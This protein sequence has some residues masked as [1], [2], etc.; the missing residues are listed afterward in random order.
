MNK[1]IT[2][3]IFIYVFVHQTYAQNFISGYSGSKILCGVTGFKEDTIN[4]KLYMHHSIVNTPCGL[5]YNYIA[6]NQNNTW[7]F[8]GPFD[9]IVFGIEI[10]NNELYACGWYSSV[11]SQSLATLAKYN[12]VSWVAV[13]GFISGINIGRLK[14]I[15]NEL[16]VCGGTINTTNGNFNG[17]AKFDGVSWSGFNIPNLG[18]PGF[19]IS[20]VVFYNNEMFIGGNFYLSTGEQDLIYYHAGLWQEPGVGLTGSMGG[21]NK[22]EI[23]KNKLYV[24]GLI[25]KDDGN[26]GNMLLVWDGINLTG[27]GDGLKD[28]INTY[29]SAQVK[30][31]MVFRNQLYIAGAFNYAG[32]I[33][34]LGLTTFDGNRFYSFEKNPQSSPGLDAIGHYKDTLW[35][36][37]PQKYLNDSIKVAGK[38]IGNYVPDTSS[39]FYDVGI[40]EYSEKYGVNIYPNPT[41]SQINIKINDAIQPDATIEIKTLLG[42]SVKTTSLLSRIDLSD[43]SNGLYFL[44]IKN[45]LYIRTF[46]IIKQ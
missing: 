17:V 33:F 39:V 31:M 38:Y 25:F 5:N 6:C 23:Y 1:T 13:P 7:S 26:P 43:L 12:G 11:N 22:L 27:V 24:G 46:K 8:L 42:Q 32:D 21:V 20:D 10:F 30:D 44:V 15:N 4:N 2:Y 40:D 41:T 34:S 36:S 29:G 18:D 37:G 35:I 9:N 3:L 14:V 16:Y 19:Y 45:G 28:N